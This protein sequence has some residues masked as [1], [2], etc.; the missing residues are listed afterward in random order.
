MRKRGM[1]WSI[2][3]ALVFG[4]GCTGVGPFEPG[5]VTG[6]LALAPADPVLFAI[7]ATR[8]LQLVFGDA[9][10]II[11][12]Q[13][14]DWTSSAPSVA[15]VNGSGLVTSV[16]D[17]TTTITAQ[18]NGL[19]GT[20]IVTVAATITYTASISAMDQSDANAANNTSSARVTVTVE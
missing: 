17:G 3:A 16:G 7:G 10:D 13:S 19:R 11:D 9:E 6:N 8:Q 14:V 2:G 5:S 4:S 18:W 15:T 12:D 20:T 1:V